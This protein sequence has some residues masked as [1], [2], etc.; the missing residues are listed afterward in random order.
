MLRLSSAVRPKPSGKPTS[1][2]ASEI[3]AVADHL[4]AAVTQPPLAFSLFGHDT[5]SVVTTVVLQRGVTFERQPPVRKEMIDSIA[6]PA[7]LDPSVR[8]RHR[9]TVFDEC[10]ATEGL[11]WTLG[12]G[13]GV[14]HHPGGVANPSPSRLEV[15]NRPQCH[16]A[17]P[18][19]EG[20]VR[21]DQ[22]VSTR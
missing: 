4:H 13:I 11:Q 21:N 20:G 3:P 1:V 7:H 14:V 18:G 22:S 9:Q 15:Q 2:V 19:R 6:I 5:P 16:L 10:Q 8:D 17:H 12:E